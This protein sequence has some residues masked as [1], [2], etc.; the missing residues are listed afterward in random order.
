[1]RY[2]DNRIEIQYRE[3]Q[4]LR[5]AAKAVL[6]ENVDRGVLFSQKERWLRSISDIAKSMKLK[7]KSAT[8]LVQMLSDMDEEDVKAVAEYT[9]SIVAKGKG[10]DIMQPYITENRKVILPVNVHTPPDSLYPD[11]YIE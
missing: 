9:E 2:V 5:D 10:I 11:D 6:V 3:C 7:K 8:V 4:I 1:M